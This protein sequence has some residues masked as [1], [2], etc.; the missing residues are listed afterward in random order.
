MHHTA[1]ILEWK[2]SASSRR[3]FVIPKEPNW[4]LANAGSAAE[5]TSPL[6]V[7]GDEHPLV[8]GLRV[9]NLTVAAVEIRRSTRLPGPDGT[10]T[11]RADDRQPNQ[12]MADFIRYD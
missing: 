8:L 7:I 12:P 10:Y 2:A 11:K 6:L 1:A 9:L 5:V 3:A 4:P